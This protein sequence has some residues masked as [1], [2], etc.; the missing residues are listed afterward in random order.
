MDRSDSLDT[1]I[2]ARRLELCSRENAHRVAGRLFDEKRRPVAVVRTGHPI[3]PFHV[4][5]DR[6]EKSSDNDHVEME[7]RA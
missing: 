1:K 4:S 6:D 3:K 5:E 2:S 7:I